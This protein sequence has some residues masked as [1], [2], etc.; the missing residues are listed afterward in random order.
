M[1]S[2]VI[3]VTLTSDFS[4]A[5]CNEM[6]NIHIIKDCGF[7]MK[8]LCDMTKTYSQMHSKDKYSHPSSINW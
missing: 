1:C 4:P 8:F 2:T 5:L 6:L 3:A 7:N